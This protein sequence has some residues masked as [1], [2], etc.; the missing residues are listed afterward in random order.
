MP[1]HDETS[2]VAP[3]AGSVRRPPAARTRS[4]GGGGGS[5]RPPGGGSGRPPAGGS[6]RPA[7]GGSGR[8]RPPAGRGGTPASRGGTSASRGRPSGRPAGKARPKKQ[9]R[10]RRL[11]IAA[12]VM[13]GLFVLLC[14]FVGVVY[15]TTEVPSPDSVS[16]KQTTVLYYADGV[17]EM[18][19]LGDENR[20]NV[21]LSE[22]SEAAQRAVLAAENRSFYTD[23]GI[24]FTGIVRA[25]WNNLTSG[26]T[27]GG[28]T[29]TQQY[30]K[31]AFLTSDQTFS[32]K[33][34]EL[35]LAIKLDNNF[36]KEQILENYLNT[37]YYGRGAYGI[38][39]AADTYFGVSAAEL[40]PQQGAVLAVLIRSPSGND[41]ETNP[42]GALERWGLVLDA[43]VDEG[44][45]TQA[46]RDASVYPPVLP[47]GDSPLG[48]PEG[49]EGH[50]VS[51]VRQEL[52]AEGYDEQ[53]IN[54][55][56]L[57]ITTTISK[58]AQDAAVAS[59][60]STLD[61]EPDN[62]RSALVSVDP[63]TGGVI[64]YYGGE[65]GVGTDFAQ[66]V[67][68][69]GSSVKP[70]VLATALEQ[71]I[72][73]RARRDG[74]SPQTFPDRPG[75]PV[76][77]SG[78]ASCGA[79]TLTEAITRSLNTT[80]Y[81][82]AYEV[83]PENVRET[84]LAAAGLPDTWED[85]NYAGNTTLA[86][87]EG[88]T[89]SSI[90]IGE[91]EMRP[92]DQA[93]G[94]AT[95]AAGG[96]FRDAY[97]VSRVADNAG[98]VLYEQPGE[99][100]EQVLPADVVND[101]TVALKDVASYSRR[102]LDGGREVASKTGTQG[103]DREDNSD[104]W[105]V[106]YTPSASTAVWMGTE[107]REP[108]RTA[109]GQIIYGAGLPGAIWQEYMNAV[110]SGVP[111]EDLPDRALITGDSGR[112]VPEPTTEAPAPVTTPAAPS[113]PSTPP[114]SSPT[115]RTPEPPVDTDGDGVPDREDFA[116]R[117]PTVTTRPP[118]PT[119]PPPPQQPP[120]DRDGDG[121]VDSED[122]EPDNP[123]VPPRTAPGS[124][125]PVVPPP[126]D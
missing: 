122:P 105:M 15:A 99:P 32:R 8:G 1:S 108:I 19:R 61:G 64:A 72:G 49:P 74:S 119:A 97:F 17:T 69:P 78:G 75:Q 3:R 126:V 65:N 13:G 26:S 60:R 92:F 73:I 29:I 30:V 48:T 41:P 70:Y 82:L 113:T 58:P 55:G 63:R 76:T 43:M 36:S 66:A 5:G 93:Q 59:A 88:L 106:G 96:V 22:V 27:Q 11:K 117:D 91:Y 80:F 116:P 101:V 100:G 103:L 38:E 98:A 84:I 85:G 125:G 40:T 47:R 118:R 21:P 102:G 42:E 23:P 90:G 114:P 83:G 24:S 25:A 121:V 34:Q 56:G 10:K 31:N 109:R 9:R 44:W 107:Y 50:I 6:G 111:E 14:V 71:G 39:A 87:A 2:P 18:A 110:L 115:P 16:T 28:S 77:N 123:A 120:A 33:F 51:Q 81:G 95:L 94:F 112:G 68:Q 67:R 104:A 86:N 54:A 4:T 89:G 45:L 79:C 62:L 20:T 52:E 57:Q 37:I 7:A 53:Q 124:P 35:F 12:G 46:E